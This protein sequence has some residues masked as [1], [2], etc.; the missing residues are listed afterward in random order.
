MLDPGTGEVSV[1]QPSEATRAVAA[2]V[3][4]ASSLGLTVHDA[5]V[6]H[7]SNRI[8]ARLVPCDAVARV[9]PVGQQ[10]AQF[11]V[12][13]AQRLIE[14]GSPVGA[15]DPRVEPR[16]F[17]RDGFEITLWTYHRPVTRG[18]VPPR[19]YADALQRL[20]L[21]MR[22]LD[23]PAPHFMDRVGQA[24]HLVSDPERTPALAEEDRQLLRDTLSR[25]T[26][27]IGE[28]GAAEQL[29]HGEPHPGNVL[30]TRSGPVFIDFETCCHGPVEFDLA[31]MPP[32]VSLH[33]PGVDQDLLG[34]CRILVQAM[35]TAWR[36][37]R[38]DRLPNGHRLGMEWLGQLR[39]MLDR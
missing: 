36:W 17:E 11:E 9:A 18:I 34:Q 4:T 10:N 19:D 2:V 20:H 24:Q 6:L 16:V 23:V 29:L 7:E 22:K 26:H 33:Y 39:V 13:L 25:L 28:R 12:E 21:G 8:T 30:I 14:T 3:A 38:D 37:D 1:Q 31:H 15:P 32:E 27:V 35:I 5:I